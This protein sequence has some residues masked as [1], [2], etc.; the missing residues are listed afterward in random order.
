MKF[1]EGFCYNEL[2][3]STNIGDILFVIPQINFLWVAHSDAMWVHAKI[4]RD[5]YWFARN[6]NDYSKRDH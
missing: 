6:T 4:V 2:V 5:T 1:D 3:C